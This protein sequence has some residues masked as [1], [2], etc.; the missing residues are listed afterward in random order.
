MEIS[1]TRKLDYMQIRLQKQY[2]TRSI[3]I[4]VMK[5]RVVTQDF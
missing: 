2:V 1:F 4:I 3:L 5:L